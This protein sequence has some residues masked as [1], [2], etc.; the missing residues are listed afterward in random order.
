MAVYEPLLQRAVD[1]IVATFRKRVAAGLQGG[2]S[3]VIPSQRE[4]ASEKTNFELVTWLV[5]LAPPVSN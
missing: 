1:S 5:V 2:R 4:Q 3:F